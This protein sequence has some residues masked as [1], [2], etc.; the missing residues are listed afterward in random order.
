MIAPPWHM[1]TSRQVSILKAALTGLE[2]FDAHGMDHP[3]DM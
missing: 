3:E 2:S 1:C